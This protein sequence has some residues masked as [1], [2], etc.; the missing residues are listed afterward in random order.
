MP[1]ILSI[2][3]EVHGDD[4]VAW[5]EPQSAL[6]DVIIAMT[7]RPFGTA[8][9]ID[10]NRRLVGLITD[11][12]LRR[13]LLSHEDIRPLCA[14]DI[15]TRRPVTISQIASF[16]DAARTMEDRPSQL[17]VLPVLE[18]HDGRCLGLVRIHDIYRSEFG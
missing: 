9:V 14:V 10:E 11:G 8:C 16:N 4:A 12:D 13:T 15:M 18:D 6:K 17:S 2:S 7:Q 5:A 3:R 1:M